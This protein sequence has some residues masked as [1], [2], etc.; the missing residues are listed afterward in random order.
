MIEA[1]RI[2]PLNDHAINPAAKYVLYWMQASQ[3]AAFNPAL[4]YAAQQANR[5]NVPLLVCFAVTANITDT[6]RRHKRFLLEGMQ[7]TAAALHERG[8]GFVIRHEEPPELAKRLSEHAALMVCDRGYLRFQREWRASL[9]E[10][11]ACR[12]V[13]IEGDVVVPVELVSNKQEY[14][15]RTIR[16]KIL[17]HREQFIQWLEETSV[18]H[19][20]QAEGFGLNSDIDLSNL[21]ATLDALNLDN[22]VLP[23]PLFTG[24]TSHARQRLEMFLEGRAKLYADGRNEPSQ[25]NSTNLSPYLHYGQIS[26]VEIAFHAQ[27]AGT[28]TGDNEASFLEELI[29]R[30]E[31]GMNYCHFQP[32]YDQYDALPDWAKKTLAEHAEDPRQP[33]LSLAQMETGDTPDPYFNAAMRQMRLT[34]YMHNYMRMYWGKRIIEWSKTPQ[35]AYANALHLNNKYFIDGRDPA[36]FISIGWLFGLHDRAWTEREIFGK[37]RFMNANGL[38]RK[39]D[40]E[41]YVR[42]CN[43][44]P[45]S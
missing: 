7:E 30:R 27:Q 44:I 16:P 17:R 12:V 13:Q 20:C 43:A 39:F 28:L 1:E 45:G 14:A 21:D 40:I 15:A 24:G 34:G 22:S 36:S 6:N 23:S 38:R 37:I 26:P 25:N 29:V 31:L 8:I 32:Q 35:E 19:P 41:A 10:Q 42:Q 5:L 2:Q 9:A 33:C 4:E 18:Q 11:V 3:R